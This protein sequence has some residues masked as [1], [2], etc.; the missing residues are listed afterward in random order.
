MKTVQITIEFDYEKEKHFRASWIW[1]RFIM[2]II[3]LDACLSFLVEEVE[4]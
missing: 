4:N 3:K 2:P 1:N